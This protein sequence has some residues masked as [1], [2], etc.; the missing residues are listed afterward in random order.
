MNRKQMSFSCQDV[1]DNVFV[2]VCLLFVLFFSVKKLYHI[3]VVNIEMSQVF[4]F[5]RE[6]F[7]RRHARQ[8]TNYKT[9]KTHQMLIKRH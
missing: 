1:A 3:E 7:W 8:I 9:L 4:Q 2:V 5:I 6:Y